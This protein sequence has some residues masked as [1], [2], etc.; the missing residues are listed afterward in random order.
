MVT[1]VASY[2]KARMRTAGLSILKSSKCTSDDFN[3]LHTGC[4]ERKSDLLHVHLPQNV[5]AD[6]Y[7]AIKLRSTVLVPPTII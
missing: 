7:P 1:S 6:L 2:P 3:C 4:G 5:C